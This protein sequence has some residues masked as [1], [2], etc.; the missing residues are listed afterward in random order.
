MPAVLRNVSKT[1]TLEQQRQEINLLAQDVYNLG[2]G[3]GTGG[4]TGTFS[5]SNGTRFAPSL[6]FTNFAT[7][8]AYLN[9]N[10]LSIASFTNEVARF[11][12]ADISFLKT[13]TLKDAVIDNTTIDNSGFNYNPGSYV[14]IST[15]GG[16]GLAAQVNATISPFVGTVVGG[17]PYT[18]GTYTYVP[19]L[20][21]SGQ[22]AIAD[23]T[24]RGL[25]GTILNT[26]SNYTPNV[27][28]DVPLQ[29]G[30]GT[31][32]IAD[33]EFA[34]DAGNGQATSVTITNNGSGY[35]LNDILTVNNS[36]LPLPLSAG[37]GFSGGSG[38][39]WQIN[40]IPYT[41][42][43]VV[44]VSNGS[45]GYQVGDVLTASNAT[46][47]FGSATGNITNGGS[48]YADGT[49]AGVPLYNV[50][51]T[52]YIVTTVSNP[53]TPPPQNVYQI[54]GN[55]Q[56]ALSLTIGNTYRFDISDLSN[57]THPFVIL[58]GN[59]DKLPDGIVV[60]YNGIAGVQDAFVD[61]IIKPT[62]ANGTTLVYSCH[63][64]PGM[65][66]TITLSSGSAGS[67]TDNVKAN[68]EVTAGAV[69]SVDIIDP[70]DGLKN[71]DILTVIPSDVGGVGTGLSYQVT[72]LATP[73]GSGF[74]YT[75]S[76]VGSL[77]S[78][79]KSSD[80]SGYQLNDVITPKIPFLI[81]IK[82]YGNPYAGSPFKFYIDLNDGNGEVETPTLTLH[83]GYIYIF[84]YSDET[85][86]P[87]GFNI[88]ETQDGIHN[89]GIPFVGAGTLID[90]GLKTITFEVLDSTPS[91][92]YYY[93]TVQAS[94]H[95]GMGGTINTTTAARTDVTP[96][97]ILI[98]QIS[99]ITSIELGLDGTITTDNVNVA[100]VSAQSGAFVSN[101]NVD[102]L[103][104]SGS[105]LAS[106]N[107]TD[108]TLTTANNLII[109]GGVIGNV[110]KKLSVVNSSNVEVFAVDLE[111]GS[112]SSID[113]SINF[114]NASAELNIAEKIKL[115]V[116]SNNYASI[117]E[118]VDVPLTGNG[119]GIRIKPDADKSVFID[120]NAS[121]AVPIGTTLERPLDAVQGS[122]RFNTTA[123][124]YEGYNGS[125]WSSLGGVRDVNNDTYIIPEKTPGSNEDVLYFY[126]F[127]KQS[128]T[129]STTDVS[130]FTARNIK[131]YDVDGLIAREDLT[132]Y[133]LG[134]VIYTVDNVY[135]VT[136][137]GSTGTA[138]PTH[139]SGAAVDGTAELTWVRA[140]AATL[141]FTNS[142]KEVYFNTPT[143]WN[144]NLKI[145]NNTISSL[146]DD[147][148]ISPLSGKNVEISSTTSLIIP[149]GD[150]NNKGAPKQ[151]SIRYNTA[152][153]QFEGFNGTQWGGLGGVKDINQDT[154]IK[155][156][157][158][159]G[160]NEDTL[161][162][163]NNSVNTLNVTETYLEFNGM[164]TVTSVSN[165]LDVNIDAVNF[166]NDSFSILNNTGNSTTK[167]L[168]TLTNFDIA[169]ASGLTTDT[170]LRLDDTGNFIVNTAHS[171][172]SFSGLTVIDK[173]LDFINL[174]DIRTKTS[175]I[176][177]VKGTTD[178][179]SFVIYETATDVSAKVFV[180][181]YNSTTGDKELIEYNVCNTSAD[182]V[183]NA[184]GEVRTS[185][186][187]INITFDFDPAL[188]VRL[189][190][191][192]DSS[193]A[194]ADQV[195]VTIIST[196]IKK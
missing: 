174:R 33:I 19:L 150:N 25:E 118:I 61:L 70:G 87:H 73:T 103:S 185:N 128:L 102:N 195:T 164:D 17:G 9:G 108:L 46:I 134:D 177:L 188:N 35:A 43:D 44:P 60:I 125:S 34:G 194:T 69:T 147:I 126:N 186:N 97:E 117:E 80:G 78:V 136:V 59:Y 158:A 83:K 47:G 31:G 82:S 163:Y 30:S 191:T 67:Y 179:G 40:A 152:D 151:G 79:V 88:S 45:G 114:T 7:T 81:K 22:N 8:G 89:G 4:L 95:V 111:D 139:T 122:I 21:G 145:Q 137:A 51:S 140:T 68:V 71:N 144:N 49:Y 141:T 112:L 85:N 143:E 54:D 155:A 26:G 120:T 72:S 110:N 39:Q 113:G 166:A 94:Q 115:A 3:S 23:I 116:D 66:N 129:L 178:S 133:S 130:F 181:T 142:V 10:A 20:N 193:V 182:I 100:S 14:A 173:D 52:T 121:I 124:Q 132:A 153:S 56:Q 65:G 168:T 159:P 15:T 13:V 12:S 154:E 63:S 74:S 28:T 157:S 99:P 101:I 41:V 119:L 104:L 161:F 165:N 127:N 160:A 5:L 55:T 50:A 42:S 36:D 84:D 138:V 76:E 6:N 175:D 77:T 91:T 32:A 38:F 96:P 75:L 169:L 24:V 131:A 146:I 92:L 192:L 18:P 58:G 93:C 109:T 167:L 162:F 183:H 64:H 48:G 29:G 189:T 11:D 123:L 172:G 190:A 184:Y 148:I 2:G 62:V 86:N 1:Y 176:P 149:V 196:I 16:S 106:A 57:D 171:T 98:D 37:G 170:L 105:T 156:E 27:Y 180:S 187:L 107:S 90:P 135:E 53:G